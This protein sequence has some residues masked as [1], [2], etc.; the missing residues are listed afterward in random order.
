MNQLMGYITH[1]L[2]ALIMTNDIKWYH[3]MPFV[4]ISAWNLYENLI[5]TIQSQIIIDNSNHH[6]HRLFVIKIAQRYCI[7]DI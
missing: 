2:R 7:Y 1:K 3:S 4:I 5:I 6:E